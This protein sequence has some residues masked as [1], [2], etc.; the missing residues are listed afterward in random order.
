MIRYLKYKSPLSW[1]GLWEIVNVDQLTVLFDLKIQIRSIKV[2]R[3]IKC[4]KTDCACYM[5]QFI[6]NKMHADPWISPSDKLCLY[7]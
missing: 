3:S 7:L 5:V 2:G 6:Q 4:E 1:A